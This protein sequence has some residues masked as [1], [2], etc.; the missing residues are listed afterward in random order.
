MEEADAV[1]RGLTTADNSWKPISPLLGTW[2]SILGN[3]CLRDHSLRTRE[4]RRAA[5]DQ[6]RAYMWE[7]L[8]SVSEVCNVSR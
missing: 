7:G 3:D 2:Q 5:L 1:N 8:I 6:G 4:L